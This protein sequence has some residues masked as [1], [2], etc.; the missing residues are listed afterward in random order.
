M[1]K[2]K[3]QAPKESRDFCS[4]IPSRM[5]RRT[6]CEVTIGEVLKARVHTVILTNTTSKGDDVEE[7]EILS[8]N[9]VSV[10]KVDEEPPEEE[11][12][13]APLSFEEGN[14]ATIDEL[15]QVDIG[16]NEHPRPIFISVSLSLEEEKAYLDLLTEFQ[17][18]FAWTYKEMPELDPKVAV[19]N[20]AVKKSVRPIKQAQ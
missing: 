9:H 10:K 7:I 18:V 11:T 8:S 4:K 14:Q 5:K 19:H 12:Q 20:L 3:T 2:K 16:T 15:K 17:D 13:D 6:K 1:K